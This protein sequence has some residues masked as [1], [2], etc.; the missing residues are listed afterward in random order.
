MK[1]I[2]TLLAILFAFG[3]ARAQLN[4]ED[5]LEGGVGDASTFMQNYMEPVFV[6]FGYGLNSG[7]YN[8]AKPHKKLGVDITFGANIVYVSKKNKYFTFNNNDYKNIA[9]SEGTSVDLPT[10][11]G[12]NLRADDLPELLILN[13][14][15]EETLRL[16]APTGL[17]LEEV[18]GVP[19]AVAFAQ[20]GIGLPKSTDLKLRLLP[21]ITFNTG[22]QQITTS[23]FGFGIMHDVKQWIPDLKN[24]PL[25]LS[26][27]IG[28]SQMK[29]TYILDKKSNPNQIASF[30]TSGVTFSAIASKQFSVVTIFSSLGFIT[31]KTNFALLGDYSVGSLIIL[32]NPI[33]FNFTSGGPKFSLGTRLKLSV[34][35]LHA[36]YTL[37]KFNT[38]TVGVG[39]S[40]R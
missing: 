36:E 21:K 38:L 26:G 23:I 3:T 28:Y 8:T 16:N 22:S 37:Q 35:T 15:G 7:W 32:S 11:S 40:V 13:S 10:A 34:F 20:I 39:M 17:G 2:V 30:K 18:Q 12:P 1:K 31:S 4:L 6:G 29:V 33:N 14:D 25:E 9:L 27:F 24:F 5:I 19:L